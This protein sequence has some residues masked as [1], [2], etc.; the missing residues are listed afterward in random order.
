VVVV[1]ILA[2]VWS[3]RRDVLPALARAGGPVLLLNFMGVAAAWG[4]AALLGLDRAQRIAVGLECGLQNFAM[5][6]FVALTLLSDAPL[7]LPG[8]AYGLTMYVSAGLV[9]LGARLRT[10]SAPPSPAPPPPGSTRRAA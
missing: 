8:I 7:L 2:A 6:A 1:I 9:V 4:A 3:V 5:A 10:A